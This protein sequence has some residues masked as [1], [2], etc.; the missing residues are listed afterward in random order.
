MVVFRRALRQKRLRIKWRHP[1]YY[2][3]SSGSGS[4]IP[5]TNSGS[6]VPNAEY[7]NV[8]NSVAI[9]NNGILVASSGKLFKAELTGSDLIIEFKGL[10]TS[11]TAGSG[12]LYRRSSDGVLCVG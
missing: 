1:S 8:V 9:C 10:P 4:L 12:R 7:Y 5:T 6:G 11:A 2:L 3:S